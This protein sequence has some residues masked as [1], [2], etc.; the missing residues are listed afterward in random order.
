MNHGFSIIYDDIVLFPLTEED[1]FRYIDLRNMEEN[2]KWFIHDQIITYEQQARWYSKYLTD[3]LDIMFA[4]KNEVS[5]FV[6]GC[7]I[8]DIDIESKS[9]EFGRLLIDHNCRGKNYGYKALEA[10]L[11]F[12]FNNLELEKIT[13][14]VFENND[15]AISCYK[16]CG[17]NVVY[18]DL[19]R[20]LLYMEKVV[21]N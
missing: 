18:K 12:G 10:V 8:Y 20:K 2:R 13:L 14:S 1:C 7:A 21:K 17:F 11:D 4:I 16:R 9:A 15:S 5:E 6:G 3:N 19:N